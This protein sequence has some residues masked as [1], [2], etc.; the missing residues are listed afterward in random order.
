[1]IGR[2]AQYSLEELVLELNGRFFQ[3]D[4]LRYIKEGSDDPNEIRVC[5]HSISELDFPVICIQSKEVSCYIFLGFQGCR[6]FRER[7]DVLEIKFANSNDTHLCLIV[8]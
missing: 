4:F 5:F 6:V 1:M 2:L 3:W 8:F 7:E